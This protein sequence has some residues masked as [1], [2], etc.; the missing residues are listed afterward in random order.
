MNVCGDNLAPGDGIGDI[1]GRSPLSVGLCFE[2]AVR[3]LQASSLS[4]FYA[5]SAQTWVPENIDD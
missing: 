2:D 5:G 3:A 4:G 1:V